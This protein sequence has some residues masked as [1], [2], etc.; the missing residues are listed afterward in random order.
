MDIAEALERFRPF[1]DQ[2][3]SDRE[4]MLDSIA[5]YP[6]IF[7]RDN[8]LAHFTASAWIVNPERTKVLMAYHKI[9][10]EWAWTGGHADGERDLLS[11]ARR[12]V[13]EETGVSNITLLSDG[14]YS[15]E[16]VPVDEHYRRGVFVSSHLHLDVCYLFEADESEKLRANELENAGVKWIAIEDAVAQTKEAKMIPVY[17]KLNEKL[18]QY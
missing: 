13:F 10:D 3:T 8:R 17:T 15:V 18:K 11:V 16:T 2:E 12:E 4:I 1:N 7:T 6:D 9:F 14:I 5:K